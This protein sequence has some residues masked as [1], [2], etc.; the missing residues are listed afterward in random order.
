VFFLLLL[1][2]WL[3]NDAVLSRPYTVDDSVINGYGAV[4]E[5]KIGRGSQSIQEKKPHKSHIVHNNFLYSL[6]RDQTQAATVGS[7]RLTPESIYV[8]YIE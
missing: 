6:N 5:M 1:L 3:L 8:N 4:T 2:G 7:P